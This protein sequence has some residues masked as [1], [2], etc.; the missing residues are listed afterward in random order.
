MILKQT[1]KNHFQLIGFSSI[2]LL[3]ILIALVYDFFFSDSIE[4][5]FWVHCAGGIFL[6]LCILTFTIYIRYLLFENDAI[7]Y[8][9]ADTI[10][11]HRKGVVTSIMI[12]DI[13]E[14][15]FNGGSYI[16][17]KFNPYR[18]FPWSDFYFIEIGLKNN[19]WIAITNVVDKNLLDVFRTEY[20]H[21]HYKMNRIFY[22]LMTMY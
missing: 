21:L 22:P 20:P 16:F 10:E 6:V 11:I 2:L 19:E 5:S 3:G 12:Q 4:F 1:Y 18:K 9:T 17:E 8:L 7:Y 15:V 13:N 14:I